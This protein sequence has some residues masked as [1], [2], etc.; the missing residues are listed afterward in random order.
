VPLTEFQ[1]E[2]A[3]LLA[4][5]RTPDSYLAGG[6]AM[7][8]APTSQRYSNDLDYFQDSEG[9]VASAFAADRA[10][11][12]SEG[13][14]L[15]IGIQQ[16]AFVRAVVRKGAGATK[17]EWVHDTAW[18]FL[19]PLKDELAGYVLHPIDLAVNKLLA[20]VGRNEPRDLLDTIY[21]H[22]TVLSLGALCWAAPGKDPGFTPLFLMTLLRRR[23]RYQPED[24]ARLLLREQPD[25][26]ALKRDWLE[27]L[28]QADAFIAACPPDEL[29]CLYFSKSK[30]AFVSDFTS[31][32]PDVVPH[33]GALGGVLPKSG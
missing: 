15:E 27:A 7:H 4:K 8:I 21:A 24:F 18:R 6:A 30:R 33:F 9:R 28:D 31:G 10:V 20:L 17:V 11:L 12:D 23:G 22:Q 32:D 13:F 25:L 16:P 5:D 2:V 19:P 14:E 29:G 1:E 3:R 26:E